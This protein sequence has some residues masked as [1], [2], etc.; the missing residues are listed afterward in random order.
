VL[1]VY[2][3]GKFLQ[4]I[5]YDT[6]TAL[7]GMIND[8]ITVHVQQK[9]M[10][11]LVKEPH[12]PTDEEIEEQKYIIV[13]PHTRVR[14]FNVNSLEEEY[15]YFYWVSD[16]RSEKLLED[17]ALTLFDAEREYKIMSEPFAIIHGFRDEGTGYG[18]LFGSTYDPED[19][20]LPTRFSLVTI[21]GL[22]RTVKDNNNYILRLSKDYTLR[23]RM[24]N[25]NLKLSN[26]HWSWKLIRKNQSSRVDRLLWKKVIEAS[27][28][29]VVLNDDFDIDMESLL[30]S[31]SRIRFDTLVDGATTRVGMYNGRVLM[32]KSEIINLTMDILFDPSREWQQV[33]I[34]EFVDKFDL[35]RIE[36]IR[37][38][39]KSIYESFTPSEINDIFFELLERSVSLNKKHPDIFKTSW[40]SIDVSNRVSLNDSND[41]DILQV[42]A[43]EF[44]CGENNSVMLPNPS[45]TPLLSPTTTPTPTPTPTQ[46]S[47]FSPTP[48]PSVSESATPT[49]TPTPSISNSA[50]PTTP[51]PTPSNLSGVSTIFITWEN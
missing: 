45:S 35:E 40:V 50:T 18:V 4:Q 26:K 51:T 43:S 42:F 46:S 37:D 2:V 29:R 21:K 48:T 9:D 15:V 11:T 38:F 30:P 1:D 23:D 10:L 24:N 41:E 19:N 3:N 20:T 6:P 49:P 17:T 36:D 27:T 34:E 5:I 14:K 33:D 32:D 39:Y 44:E 12:E 16:M 25:K 7:E 22:S 8:E 31:E 47:G 13:Y 28:E